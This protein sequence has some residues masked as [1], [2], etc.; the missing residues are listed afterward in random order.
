MTKRISKLGSFTVD[1]VSTVDKG[2]NRRGFPIF[3]QESQMSDEIMKAVLET[4]VDEEANIA[5]FIKKN[6][7]DESAAE[8]L[9]G[10]LRIVSSFRDK[11][12][13]DTLA[14]LAEVAGYDMPVAKGAVI[15]AE[16]TPPE[17]KKD[18]EDKEE[19]E[20]KKSL[21]ALP[22]D[23]QKQFEAITKAQDDK[24]AELTAQNEKVEKALKVEQDTRE[25]NVWIGKAKD[26]LDGLPGK[27][28]AELGAIF[29]KLA[30]VD[31]DIANEQFEQMK[32]AAE[33]IKKGK[34]F[35]EMGGR[36][37]DTTGSGMDKINKAAKALMEKS[38]GMT[39]E[40]AKVKVMEDNPELYDAYM[41]ENPA[42]TG[43]H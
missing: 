20:M 17:K 35:D 6:E 19:E 10:T 30:D 43:R 13:K 26:E 41:D 9:T 12:P 15:G 7:L 36:G 28:P 11:L 27:T 4:K 25:L 8:A 37:A 31:P 24:I 2:A 42:Q 29:K 14:T 1:E 33:A 5:E 38:D 34:L 39:I 18:M 40:Q 23:V 21:E 32:N 16:K 3:K 22:E